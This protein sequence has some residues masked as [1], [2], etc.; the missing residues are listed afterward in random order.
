MFL[1]GTSRRSAVKRFTPKAWCARSRR[2]LEA[3]GDDSFDSGNVDKCN[4]YCI[5][6]AGGGSESQP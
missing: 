4:Q 1:H 6:A 2:W 3:D 5:G